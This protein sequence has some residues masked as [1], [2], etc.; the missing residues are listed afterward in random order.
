MSEDH[1]HAKLTGA[2]KRIVGGGSIAIEVC[3][4]KALRMVTTNKHGEITESPWEVEEE[5]EDEMPL[6]WDGKKHND[7]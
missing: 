2:I 6:L 4:C 5:V 7:N 1:K 3:K